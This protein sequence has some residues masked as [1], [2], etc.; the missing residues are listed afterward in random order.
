[1]QTPLSINVAHLSATR[2]GCC[3]FQNLSF[4]VGA[5]EVLQILGPNGVGK[6]TLLKI[7]AGLRAS[8]AGVV[9]WNGRAVAEELSDYQAQLAY[10]G[11]RLGLKLNLSVDEN[12]SCSAISLSERAS[13]LNFLALNSYH[14]SLIAHLSQGQKQRVALARVCLSNKK[15]WILDEPFAALDQ[16]GFELFQDLMQQHLL[17]GGLVVLSSHRPLEFKDRVQTIYLEKLND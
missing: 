11:H 10:L 17:K 6:S 3:L 16:S 4:K 14:H 13:V 9:L 1:M 8:D 2:A 15:I 5:G 7:L 12:L